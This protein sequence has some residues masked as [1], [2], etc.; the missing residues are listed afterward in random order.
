MKINDLFKLLMIFYAVEPSTV[1]SH[2]NKFVPS[3]SRAL[4]SRILWADIV[5]H[6]LTGK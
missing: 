6:G 2:F 4:L 1:L 5:L 3:F